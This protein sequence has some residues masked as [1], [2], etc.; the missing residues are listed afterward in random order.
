MSY[1]DPD[2]WNADY[3]DDYPVTTNW[4]MSGTFNRAPTTPMMLDIQAIQRL[5]GEATSGPL[6]GGASAS[7]S[8]AA[9][10]GGNGGATSTKGPTSAA[11]GV[12]DGTVSVE[13][14]CRRGCWSEASA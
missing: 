11:G 5:Y 13:G 8:G 3:F 2:N 1:I 6:A 12:G 9:V 7:T 10:N 4:G 14:H